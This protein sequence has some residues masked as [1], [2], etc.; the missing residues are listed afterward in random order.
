[1]AR[2][3]GDATVRTPAQTPER[4]RYTFSIHGNFNNAALFGGSPTSFL[5]NFPGEHLKRV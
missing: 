4:L 1:M 3:A 5:A 2:Q